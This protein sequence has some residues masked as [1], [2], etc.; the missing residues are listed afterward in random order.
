VVLLPVFDCSADA[1]AVATLARCYPTRRI[2]PIDCGKLVVG[3][4]TLHCLTQQ[5]PAP[6]RAD[7][8]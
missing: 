3:L 1:L 8:R 6:L 4:G 2:V 7:N 5:I